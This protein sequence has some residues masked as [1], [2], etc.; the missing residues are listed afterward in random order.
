MLWPQ[1]ALALDGAG[2]LA[3]V[4]H[5]HLLYLQAVLVLVR[6]AGHDGDARVHRPLVASRED[7][8]GAV[9]PGAFGDAVQQVAP[10]RDK[11]E[12]GEGEIFA[13]TH[14]H[15]HPH[16][17]LKPP[18]VCPQEPWTNYFFFTYLYIPFCFADLYTIDYFALFRIM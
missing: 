1:V 5:V 12:G 13:H 7:D 6:H 18:P 10:E 15:T 11:E 2:V 9:Q 4:R 8:A 14:T 16:R 17:H 3:V